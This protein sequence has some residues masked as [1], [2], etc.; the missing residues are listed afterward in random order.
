MQSLKRLLTRLAAL[1]LPACLIAAVAGCGSGI[2]VPASIAPVGASTPSIWVGAWGNSPVNAVGSPANPG[3][4]EQ[5]YR[6][7]VYPTISGTQERVRFSNYFGTTPVTIGSSRLSIGTDGT[8]AVDAT[9]DVKL[10]FNNGSAS[11]TL[12]PGQII[13]SDPVKLTYSYGQTLAVSMYLSG[14]FQPLTRHDSLFNQNYKTAVGAGD[15]TSDATGAAFTQSEGSWMLLNGIDVYGP[16]Q[17]TV[18]MLG[19]ST[20][21]GF[22]SN[23]GDTNTYPVANVAVAGQHTGRISDQVAAQLNAAGYQIGVINAGISGNTITDVSTNAGNH[24]ENA[25]DRL[26][27]DVLSQPNVIA[28]VTYLGSID[29]R[30]V[31]CKSAPAIETAT[32]QLVAAAAAAKVRVLLGTIPPSAFCTNPAQANFGPTPTRENPYAGGEDGSLNGGEVQRQALNTWI[33]TTGATLP[34]VVGVADYDQALADPARPHFLQPAYNSGDNYHP[35]GAGY[36]AESKAVPLNLLLAP[37]H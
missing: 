25:V 2:L 36:K 37:T 5:S 12:A 4:S 7:L 30:S 11:V 31:D 20:T 33:R 28:M 23:Y 18:V 21:D 32:Q 10:T 14:S 6:F 15:A 22:R 35:N 13:V 34:G 24:I 8:A 29:I 27:R 3:G 16:Y 9:H 19:S 26:Q 1:S 17:G